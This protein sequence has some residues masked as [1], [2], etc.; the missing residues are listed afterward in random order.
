MSIKTDAVCSIF[1]FGSTSYL[2]TG[3]GGGKITCL[4]QCAC[5]VWGNNLDALWLKFAAPGHVDA[6]RRQR[7]GN[8]GS[9][10]GGPPQGGTDLW[11]G[12]CIFSIIFCRYSTMSLLR[13]ASF[14][15]LT[16]T[17]LICSS[18]IC[19]SLGIILSVCLAF[20]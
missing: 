19:T 10:S 3:K 17:M 11:G 12:Y 2:T 15:I 6:R 13:E 4:V 7:A 16:S 20:P 8:D 18:S 14:A 5:C 1:I 9:V